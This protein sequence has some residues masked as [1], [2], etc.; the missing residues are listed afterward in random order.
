MSQLTDLQIIARA[1]D[2]AA[3]CH[4][5]QRRKGEAAEPYVN[6]LAEVASLLADAGADASLVAA[7][8]LHDTMEDQAVTRAELIE[9]CNVDVADLVAHVMDDKALPK[10]RRKRLQVEHAP[11]LSARAQMLKMA[12][13]ISNLSALLV[14]PPKDWSAQRR[15]AYFEWAREVVDGC[16]SAHAGLAGKIDALYKLRGLAAQTGGCGQRA[17]SVWREIAGPIERY[18]GPN[19]PLRKPSPCRMVS[20]ACLRPSRR[21]RARAQQ[22]DEFFAAPKRE[23]VGEIGR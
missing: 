2:F 17:D 6:H 23:T 19:A 20:S 5:D 11:H 14:S 12:D 22:Q 7:G 3:R 8:Y 1:A 9:L 10:G 21:Q 18:S 16:R 15:L 13:K 4:T